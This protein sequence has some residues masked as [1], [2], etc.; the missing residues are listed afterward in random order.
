MRNVILGAVGII[1][2]CGACFWNE[3][4]LRR[5]DLMREIPGQIK[6]ALTHFEFPPTAVELEADLAGWAFFA[7]TSITV[8]SH[9]EEFHRELLKQIKMASNGL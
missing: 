4:R 7:G 9:R 2:A 5:N 6:T 3:S 8:D 1:A